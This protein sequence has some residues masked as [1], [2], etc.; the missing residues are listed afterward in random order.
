MTDNKNLHLPEHFDGKFLNHEASYI[1]SQQ[2][3]T[4]E[5]DTVVAGDL[6]SSSEKRERQQKKLVNLSH[7]FHLQQNEDVSNLETIEGYCTINNGTY[8]T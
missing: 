8:C 4:E 3:L 2:E 1:R 5:S 6:T 7:I